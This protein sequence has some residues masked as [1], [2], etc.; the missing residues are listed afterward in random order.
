VILKLSEYAAMLEYRVM[1]IKSD[2]TETAR[3]VFSPESLA[4]IEQS[5]QGCCIVL[6]D[7]STAEECGVPKVSLWPALNSLSRGAASCC[8]TFPQP[9]SAACPRSSPVW[10]LSGSLN[11]K[12]FFKVFRL[13]ERN[14]ASWRDFNFFEGGFRHGGGF[15][16]VLGFRV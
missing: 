16:W 12:G 8:P 15:Y 1:P 6:P 10:G 9:R 2:E 13:P 11:L 7:I 5:Q 3:K 14:S 4:S